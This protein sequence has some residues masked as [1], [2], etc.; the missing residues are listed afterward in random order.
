MSPTVFKY[1]NYRFFFFS[2]EEASKVEVQNISHNGI[3]I[4]AN[5]QE[6]YMPFNEFPW[7]LNATIEQIYNLEFFHGKHLYWP[8]LDIDIELAS[9]KH[10][11]AYPLKYS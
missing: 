5:D 3:W 10:P 1:K 11:E 4:L 2:R 8:A 9:I 7:F 6:F